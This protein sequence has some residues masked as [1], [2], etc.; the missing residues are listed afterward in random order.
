MR[1]DAQVAS[2]YEAYRRTFID[3]LYEG[4]AAFVKAFEGE[5]FCYW[6][7]TMRKGRFYTLTMQLPSYRIDGISVRT[8]EC[9]QIHQDALSELLS[10][11]TFAQDVLQPLLPTRV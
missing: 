9:V 4:S 11:L 1:K 5:G 2:R 3:Q 10:A 8:T 7:N 6:S